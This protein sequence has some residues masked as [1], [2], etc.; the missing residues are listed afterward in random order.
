MVC[1]YSIYNKTPT[2]SVMGGGII[3]RKSHSAISSLPLCLYFTRPFL[4]L[5]DDEEKML[6]KEKTFKQEFRD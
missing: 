3:Q 1:N 6:A 2:D 4:Q 5:H